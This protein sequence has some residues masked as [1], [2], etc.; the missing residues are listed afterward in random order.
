MAFDTLPHQLAWSLLIG[1]EIFAVAALWPLSEWAT[2]A[3]RHRGF[4]AAAIV[5]LACFAINWQAFAFARLF[6]DPARVDLVLAWFAVP[7]FLA[8]PAAVCVASGQS[9]RHAGVPPRP[10]RAIALTVG[11]ISAL[12]APLAAMS[13]ACGLG[14]LCL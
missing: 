1:A 8:F 7:L 14:G 4:V 9:L 2:T 13:A 10:A 3:W 11:A 12:V 5:T 6:R